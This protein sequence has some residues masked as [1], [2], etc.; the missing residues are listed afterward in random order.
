MILTIDNIV[1]YICIEL[2]IDD[3]STK[4]K[5]VISILH[6]LFFDFFEGK[7]K[8]QDKPVNEKVFKVF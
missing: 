4:V 8:I 2:K 3:G 1:Q 6:D 5:L 7:C